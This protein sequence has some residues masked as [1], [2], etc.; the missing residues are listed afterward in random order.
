MWGGL[1]REYLTADVGSKTCSWSVGLGSLQCGLV[2]V[3]QPSPWSNP[4][5]HQEARHMIRRQE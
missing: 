3:S 1:E 4:L 5:D 2:L